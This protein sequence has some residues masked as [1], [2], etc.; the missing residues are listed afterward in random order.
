MRKLPVLLLTALLVLGLAI[1]ASAATLTIWESSDTQIEFLKKMG[2]EYKK[3]TGVD[4]RVYKVAHND[5]INKLTLDGPAGKGPDIAVWVHDGIGEAVTKGLI[6][7]LPLA[8]KDLS[9]FTDS[10]VEAMKYKGKI[11]G[12][13]Y[14][15]ETVALIYNKDLMP[16]PPDTMDELL[17]TAKKLTKDT[18]GDGKAE[19]YGFLYD[20]T[21][22]YFGFGFFSGYGG[23]VFKQTREGLDPADIGLAN[24]GAVKAAKFIKSLH[25]SGLIPIGTT[26]DV[27]D[28]LFSGKKLA[29][30]I[31]GPWAFGA[32]KD[33]GL[34]YGIAPLPKLENGQYPRTFIGVKTYF[35]SNF[36]KQKE[37]ALKFL[38]WLTNK[39]NSYL[40][41][42]ETAIIPTRA[43]VIS[44]PEFQK[45][46][47]LRAFAIQA[48]RGVPMPSIPEMPRV[49]TPMENGLKMI[50]QNQAAPEDVLRQAVE[51]I[52]SDIKDMKK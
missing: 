14:G 44:M 50:M 26:Y 36:S 46:K 43:D 13:P 1:E 34:N 2:Q 20:T 52:K 12:L 25:T 37:E 11:Y 38:R 49:W 9:G 21:N 31:N 15:V 42:K 33:A 10:A 47:D 30:E 4:L 28:G 41:Y 48:S 45:D 24:E 18:N 17:K 23:Y 22:F 40:Q 5:Q 3:A 8:E 39:E 27:M 19:Q 32:Y 6:W 16:D 51:Q 7:P 29:A 35:I